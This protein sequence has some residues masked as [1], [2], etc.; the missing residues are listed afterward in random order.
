MSLFRVLQE[1][2]ECTACAPHL[3]LGPKPLLAA[4]PKSRIVIIG[5]AP[6]RATHQLGIPW[7]DRSGDTLRRWLGISAEDF[8]DPVKVAL[9]PMGFCYPG[10]GKNGDFEPRPQCA[11]LWHPRILPWLSDVGLTLYLG[12]FSVRHYLGGRF[13][14]LTEAV[15]SFKELLPKHMVLPH[16]SP[17]NGPWL[18]KRQ[19]FEKA[20]LPRLRDCVQSA[21][22]GL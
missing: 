22:Q 21:L 18:K 14:D 2:R 10:T 11:P 8:Y 20:A 13:A 3:P 17:R 1:A 16:P 4:H 9:L 5:Q 15:E 6:G 12:R 7:S 19:W